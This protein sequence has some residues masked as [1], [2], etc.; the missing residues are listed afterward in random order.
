MPSYSEF[1]SSLSLAMLEQALKNSQIKLV[2]TE[3]ATRL[4]NEVLP[5]LMAQ[6]QSGL[7]PNLG[8]LA[9]QHSMG[10]KCLGALLPDYSAEY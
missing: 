1:D 3:I 5:V 8:S 6:E 7:S 4:R 10:D 9:M 2:L